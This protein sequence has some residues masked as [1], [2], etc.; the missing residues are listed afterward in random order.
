MYSINKPKFMQSQIQ[1]SYNKKERHSPQQRAND[2][3]FLFLLLTLITV[4]SMTIHEK[5][6]ENSLNDENLHIP[7]NILFLH[8]IQKSLPHLVFYFVNKR[9]RVRKDFY[10]ISCFSFIKQLIIMCKTLVISN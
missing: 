6:L 1:Y 9:K 4:E 10:N 5:L 3:L 8:R 2:T 7:Q